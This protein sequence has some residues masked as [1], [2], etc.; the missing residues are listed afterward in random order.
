MNVNKH[1]KS[2]ELGGG[3]WSPSRQRHRWLCAGAA[4]TPP[5]KGSPAPPPRPAQY[6]P[7]EPPPLHYFPRHAPS[8]PSTALNSNPQP[9]GRPFTL[10]KRPT[11]LRAS[12]THIVY[13]QPASSISHLTSCPSQR[14]L[15]FLNY[16]PTRWPSG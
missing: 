9:S 14:L 6:L 2:G 3:N 7:R 11:N 13:P 8:Q 4:L 12:K 15:Q 5:Q 16:R 10:H 1:G